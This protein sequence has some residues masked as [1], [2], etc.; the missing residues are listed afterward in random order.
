MLHD[1]ARHEPLLDAPW[2]EA[3]VRAAIDR[4]VS[5]TEAAFVEGRGW[6]A[7][8][9][10]VEVGADSLATV[11]HSLY[12]GSA[13]VIWALRHLRDTN[14]AA[15]RRDYGE[16]LDELLVRNRAQLDD[17]ASRPSWLFGDTPI[18]LMRYARRPSDA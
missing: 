12:L 3:V 11:Q 4:I 5:G 7:H 10:D 13:G 14:A 9:R 16:F 15:L 17:V 18:L 1:P 6:P 8:P 2:N